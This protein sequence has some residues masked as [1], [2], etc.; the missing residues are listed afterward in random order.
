MK[1]TITRKLLLIYF[2][3]ALLTVLSSTYAITSLYRINHLAFSLANRDFTLLNTAKQMSVVLIDLESAEK[4]YLIL[5]DPSIEAIY[6]TRSAE[7]T[8]LGTK[9]EKIAQGKD[10]KLLDHILDLNRQHADTFRREVLL[11]AENQPDAAASLSGKQAKNLMDKLTRTVNNLQKNAEAAIHTQLDQIN[12]QGEKFSRMTMV[13][14]TVSL[15]LGLLLAL[16]ITYNISRP[17]V[18]LKRATGAIA[19]GQFDYP[20]DIVRDDEIGSLAKA[21]RTMKD[22]LKI[23]EAKLR[24]ESPLTGLPGNR[25][26][27]EVVEKRLMAK[28]LFSLC[29]VDLDHFKPFADKYGYGWGSEVIKEVGLLIREK[30][31]TLGEQGDFVGHI[32]G[33]DFIIIAEPE[34]A[35]TICHAVVADFDQ[36]I[37]RYYSENDRTIGFIVGK[38]RQGILRKFPLISVTI[39]VV[40]DDGTRFAD[41]LDMAQKAAELKEQIKALRGNNVVTLEEMESMS[42]FAAIDQA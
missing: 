38:D 40:T 28:K 19:E 10:R 39:A 15:T 9:T 36:R 37:R 41:S 1:L 24:D 12:T 5:K 29:H 16:I 25:A 32:G 6:W 13:L 14:S 23:L 27:E 21:F 26:I 8:D 20:V 4:K 7:L 42:G 35:L 2:F 11:I 31:S 30:L 18:K 33:D 3:M 22:R 17:L 34:R